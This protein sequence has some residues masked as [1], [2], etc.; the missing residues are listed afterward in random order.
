MKIAIHNRENSFSE[1]WIQFCNEKSIDYKIVNAFDSNIVQQIEDCDAFL[2]HHHH[3]HSK[4]VIT[5]KRILFA[6]EHAGIKVFPNYKTGW[7]FDDKVAQKYLLE[8]V[9]APLV[10]S[11][12]FYD[13][14][15]AISWSK[16]TNYPK[17]FKLKGGAGAANVKLVKNQLEAVKLINKAFSRGFKQFDRIEYLKDSISK[18]RNKQDSSLILAR[19]FARLFIG[20]EFSNKHQSESQYVYFQEF[21][22]NNTFD[23][24]VIVINNKAFAIKRLVRDNDFRAS[25]SGK[26]IYDH[27]EIDKRILEIAFSVNKE[28]QS[29]CTAFDFVYDIQGQPLIVEISYGFAVTPYDKCDGYWDDHLKWY[30][31]KFNPQ[32]WII[33][34]LFK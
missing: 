22:P 33:E 9:G 10:P 32:E 12:V 28:I 15:S 19:G 29:Q 4:D 6:L 18:F 2:W 23:I 11:Y 20:T 34:N 26:V 17:V 27:K 3:S 16:Q 25:G 30:S 8:A 5:A 24:R 14:K 7:H 1:R 21:L 13:K 31:E